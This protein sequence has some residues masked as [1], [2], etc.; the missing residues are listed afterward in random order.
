M[1][2]TLIMSVSQAQFAINDTC[3][4]HFSACGI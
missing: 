4:F 3:E 2:I 1:H